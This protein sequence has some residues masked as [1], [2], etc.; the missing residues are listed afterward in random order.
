MDY[1]ISTQRKHR[2][3]HRLE[4]GEYLSRTTEFAVRG[5]ELPQSKL[6]DADVLSIRSAAK[7]REALRQHIRDTLSNDALSKQFGVHLRT[8]EKVLQYHT[9]SHVK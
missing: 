4:R 5:E 7:Q 2:P 8:I 9:C 6:M 3:D 1:D